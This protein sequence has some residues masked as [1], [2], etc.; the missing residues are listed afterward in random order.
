MEWSVGAM[1]VGSPGRWDRTKW[2]ALESCLWFYHHGFSGTHLLPS[3][4]VPVCSLEALSVFMLYIP[5]PHFV[6]F[7]THSFCPSPPLAVWCP[8]VSPAGAFGQV[9][10][11]ISLPKLNTSS[12]LAD[13]VHFLQLHGTCVG[14]GD[15]LLLIRISDPGLIP[16]FRKRQSYLS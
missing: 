8:R 1:A 13:Q 3:P 15:G 11:P 12:N 7:S 5:P 6:F 14:S 10:L 16:R 2:Y 4:F 9:H